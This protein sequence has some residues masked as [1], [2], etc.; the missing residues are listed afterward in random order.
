MAELNPVLQMVQKV[1]DSQGEMREDIREIKSRLG[2]LQSDVAG[3]HS[4][5]AEQPI[6]MDRVERRVELKD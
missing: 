1:L 6:R 3:L 2:R 4:F 5:L